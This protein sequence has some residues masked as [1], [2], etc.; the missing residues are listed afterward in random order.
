MA[1]DHAQRSEISPGRLLGGML[2][3]WG[4]SYQHTQM[5]LGLNSAGGNTVTL[6]LF[7]GPCQSVLDLFCSPFFVSLT[8]VYPWLGVPS[9]CP[10]KPAIRN[11]SIISYTQCVMTLSQRHLVIWLHGFLFLLLLLLSFKIMK[12]NV[13]T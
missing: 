2:F 6:G 4:S 11:R 7:L 8:P 10:S 5:C 3:W 1:N 13:A 9:H 12:Y